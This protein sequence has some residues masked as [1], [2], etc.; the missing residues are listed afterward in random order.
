MRV[1]CIVVLLHCCNVCEKK[2]KHQKN[3]PLVVTDGWRKEK[4]KYQK[5]TPAVVTVNREK[6]E[7]NKKTQ[8]LITSLSCTRVRLPPEV[9]DTMA[10]AKWANHLVAPQDN[11][12]ISNQTINRSIQSNTIQYALHRHTHAHTH[13]GL[14]RRALNDYFID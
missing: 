14:R 5:N 7:K 13:A 11:E 12:L 3:T 4:R 6:R 8:I 2:E 9:N 1:S 10:G